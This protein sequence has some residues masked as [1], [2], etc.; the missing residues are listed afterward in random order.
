M[1]PGESSLDSNPLMWLL[2]IIVVILF[3]AFWSHLEPE[4]R[5]MMSWLILLG[6]IGAAVLFFAAQT[7]H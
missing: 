4:L 6:C 1:Y 7:P 5:K 3:I 2:L